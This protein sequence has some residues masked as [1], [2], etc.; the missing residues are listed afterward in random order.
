M[1]ERREIRVEDLRI[2]MY[3]AEL[4]RPWLDTQ[5]AFQGFPITSE[6]ELN[7]LRQTCRKVYVDPEKS[8]SAALLPPL[9]AGA[10]AKPATTHYPERLPVEKEL[11][12]AKKL[13][14]ECGETLQR[15]LDA[16]AAGAELDAGAVKRSVEKIADSIERNPDAMLLLTRVGQKDHRQLE[17]ALAESVLMITFGRFLQLPREDLDT[18]GL[19][20]LLQDI[21]KLKMPDAVLAKSE[22]LSED[23]TRALKLHVVHS[24]A[25]LRDAPGLPPGLAD[26][27]LLHHERFDGGGY[28]RGLAGADIPMIGHIAA[29]VNSFAAMT[30]SRPYAAQ[31]APSNALAALYKGRGTRYHEAL[32]EQFIQCIGIYPVG[33]VVELNSG[34]VGVVIAQNRVR[35]LQPRVM[36]L[37]DAQFA[38][39][40]PQKILDLIKEPKSPTGEPYRIRRTLESSKLP[41]DPRDFFL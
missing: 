16:L 11:A 7:L 24:A 2:G 36:V 30:G 13:L 32:V 5:F 9:P 1:P 41:L 19:V 28:P 33:S 37:L 4:D 15:S 23:E 26:L 29:I 14:R 21:G 12:P 10:A 27:V 38:P 40:V 34:E 20:G 22:P 6:A 18:M 8:A 17:R 25:I 3:V 39:V 35:R 31:M